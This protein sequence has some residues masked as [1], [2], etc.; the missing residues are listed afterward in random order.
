MQ[1][2]ESPKCD[3]RIGCWM[4]IIY[5]H[6]TIVKSTERAIDKIWKV[7]HGTWHACDLAVY[8]AAG[9]L[10]AKSLLRGISRLSNQL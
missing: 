2:V 3:T 10:H 6:W 4:S 8:V 7:C 5:P 1:N 9:K